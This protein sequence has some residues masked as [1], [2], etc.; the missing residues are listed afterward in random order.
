HLDET[1][2]MLLQGWKRYLKNGGEVFI[3]YVSS[4]YD[5]NTLIDEIKSYYWCNVLAI[6]NANCSL[7][8]LWSF[9]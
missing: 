3:N 6:A 8:N 2:I 5:E 9:I 7:C 1:Y 4:P